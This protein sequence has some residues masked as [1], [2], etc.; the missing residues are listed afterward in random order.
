MGLHKG[1]LKL[2]PL[3]LQLEKLIPERI[4][5]GRILGYHSRAH[6]RVDGVA[7]VGQL[8]GTFQEFPIGLVLRGPGNHRS[9]EAVAVRTN[10][11]RALLQDQRDA[12]A[13]PIYKYIIQLG[14]FDLAGELELPVDQGGAVGIDGL[15]IGVAFPEINPGSIGEVPGN[16]SRDLISIVRSTLA[17]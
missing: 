10:L 2:Y 1:F 4:H 9:G 5:I 16:N 12:P 17:G 13:Y 11:H 7:P 6:F 15:H 3:I 14:L 8:P